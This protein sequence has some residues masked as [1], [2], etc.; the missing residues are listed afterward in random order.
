MKDPFKATRWVARTSFQSKVLKA[1]PAASQSSS[2]HGRGRGTGHGTG[3]KRNRRAPKVS[4]NVSTESRGELTPQTILGYGLGSDS[5]SEDPA[6]RRGRPRGRGT[7]TRTLTRKAALQAKAAD[8]NSTIKGSAFPLIMKAKK[9]HKWSRSD[10][11]GHSQDRWK[12]DS[13]QSSPEDTVPSLEGTVTPEEPKLSA[14][15]ILNPSGPKASCASSTYT[16]RTVGTNAI[17]LVN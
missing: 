4:S 14:S 10:S 16:K 17:L 8:Q 6:T 5:R 9:G 3:A 12:R 2:V 15:A 13:G 7:F 11:R 1:R